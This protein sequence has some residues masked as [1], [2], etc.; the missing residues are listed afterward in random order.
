[1]KPEIKYAIV[2]QSKLSELFEESDF[3]FE[4]LKNEENLTAFI[5]ALS[6]IVPKNIYR[7]LVGE[8]TDL[9]GFNH[10]ANRLILKYAI[11]D[12]AN[13]DND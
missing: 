6:N 7:K 12:E 5:H 4:D 11:I 9:L 10:I 13:E 2:I 1:M 3:D 8:E